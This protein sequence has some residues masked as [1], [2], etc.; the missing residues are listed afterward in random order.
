MDSETP[1]ILTHAR[2]SN[3]FITYHG[4]VLLLEIALLALLGFLC[5]RREVRRGG[6]VTSNALD[7]LLLRLRPALGRS[8]HGGTG[9]HRFLATFALRENSH[10]N[11]NYIQ[12]E[13][14]PHRYV[15]TFLIAFVHVRRKH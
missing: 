3:R 12:K 6:I 7:L 9:G 2:L 11:Q 13:F 10:T 4:D 14:F 5:S 8:H 15:H 1:C